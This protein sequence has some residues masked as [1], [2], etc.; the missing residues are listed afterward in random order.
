MSIKQIL[1]AAALAGGAAGCG[2]NFQ[3]RT[4]AKG[5]VPDPDPTANACV[6]DCSQVR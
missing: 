1:A 2:D 5:T 3:T 4:C 6:P